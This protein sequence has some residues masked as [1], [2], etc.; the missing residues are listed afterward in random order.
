MTQRL[1]QKDQRIVKLHEKGMRDL[2]RI[3]Q[4]IGYNGKMLDAG[5]ERVREGLERA[6]IIKTNEPS[7]L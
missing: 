1:S 7:G 2:S 6:G 3:A 4:K 5:V